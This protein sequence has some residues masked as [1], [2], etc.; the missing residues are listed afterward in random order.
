[1]L[2]ESVAPPVVYAN[3]ASRYSA[4][5]SRAAQRC[6]A[7]SEGTHT[8]RPRVS[9]SRTRVIGDPRPTQEHRIRRGGRESERAESGRTRYTVAGVE[10]QNDRDDHRTLTECGA[11]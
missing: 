2:P 4:T 5:S 9:R 10:Q 3:C 7:E 11:T 1:M 8:N 6:H